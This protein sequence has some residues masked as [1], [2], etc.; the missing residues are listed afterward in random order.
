MCTDIDAYIFI[1]MFI[2]TDRGSKRF[3]WKIL[4]V[5][6][7]VN[8]SEMGMLVKRNF[9]FYSKYYFQSYCGDIL[10]L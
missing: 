10:L 4:N 5:L 6:I 1:C 3:I 7:I 8:M 2:N 9:R